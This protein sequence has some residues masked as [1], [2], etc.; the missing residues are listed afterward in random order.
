MTL[1]LRPRLDT[2]EHN[3]GM[4]LATNLAV[5]DVLHAAGTGLYRVMAEPTERSIAR[6]RHTARAFGLDWPGELNLLEF[7]RTLPLGEPRT[8]AFLI[9]VRRAGGG[10]TY[11]A[12]S[13]GQ[14]PWHAAM[15]ATYAHATAPLRRLA[16]R[17]VVEA[18]LA[19]ANDR[20]VPEHVQAAFGELPDVMERRETVA[21]RVDSAVIELAEAVVLTG[22]EGDVFDAVVV[23]EDDRGALVQL[24]DPPVMVRVGARRVDPGDDVRVKVTAVDVDARRVQAERVG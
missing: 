11:E 5:A 10:A 7:Q 18:A 23:D 19:V 17:Y 14:R 4:S 9:A 16:D 24:A 6:L 13:A 22:R 2:E 3:A 1:V 21:G 8:S 15:A 20:P 12:Y